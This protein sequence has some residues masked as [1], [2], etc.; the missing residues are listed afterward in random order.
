M[1]A[2][3]N[4]SDAAI[5]NGASGDLNGSLGDSGWSVVRFRRGSRTFDAF[6]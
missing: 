6:R 4:E 5:V 3:S 2:D 1:S